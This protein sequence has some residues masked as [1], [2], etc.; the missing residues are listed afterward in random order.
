[1][2]MTPDQIKA[3][4]ELLAFYVE[5]GVDTAI[6]EEAVDRFADQSASASSLAD[7]NK[8]ST[9]A[10]RSLATGKPAR[11]VSMICVRSWNISTGAP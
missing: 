11:R 8:T 5:A 1:M 7:E 10:P 6:G 3:A 2:T 4:R 9:S